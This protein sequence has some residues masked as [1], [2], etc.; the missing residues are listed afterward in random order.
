M[1][2]KILIFITTILIVGIVLS[3]VFLPKTEITEKED[4]FYRFKSSQEIYSLFTD[5]LNQFRHSGEM[6][7]TDMVM[8]RATGEDKSDMQTPAYSETN[9]QV[10]GVDEAD[11]IKTDGEYIYLIRNN[12]DYEKYIQISELI[13]VKA[14]QDIVS[15]NEY[16]NFH[17]NEMFIEK[18]KVVLFGNTQV[19]HNLIY[20]EQEGEFAE[21]NSVE[22]DTDDGILEENEIVSPT[23][24]R[25]TELTSIKIIDIKDKENQN[26][27]KSYDFEGN[28]KTSRKINEHVYFV[29]DSYPK[30][31]DLDKTPTCNQ[32]SP[33]YRETTNDENK[34]LDILVSCEN[35]GYISPINPN[36]FITVI[37]IDLETL[38]LEKEV[39]VGSSQNIYSSKNNLYIAQTTWPRYDNIGEPIEEYFE[40]TV[41]TKFNLDKGKIKYQ[42]TGRVKGYVLNQ[43][44]MDEDKE[45]FRIATT[46]SANWTRNIGSGRLVAETITDTLV[47]PEENL[48][49]NNLYVLD[50][51]LKVIGKIEDIAPGEKIYSARFM[52]DK[53]YMI[54]FVQ[55]DPLFVIDLKDPE[56]PKILGELKIPGYSD[57]LHPYSENYL[58]GIGKEVL[59]NQDPNNDFVYEQGVKISL[60]D[61]TDLENPKEVYKEV[62]GDRGTYSRALNDHKAFFFDKEKDLLIIPITLA[63]H[64]RPPENEWMYGTYTYQGMYVYKITPE[65]GFNL[66]GKITHSEDGP[67]NYNNFQENQ[68]VKRTLYVGDVLYTFSENR[69]QLNNLN[70]LE[71]IKKIYFK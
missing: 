10:K 46:T 58:I 23:Y 15:R 18:D 33:L 19:D 44:S 7:Q 43:F 17:I 35:I 48:S 29:I 26:I 36:G 59:E 22:A 57:Y 54:T 21:I 68:I 67:N 39:I 2:R 61:V 70:N 60:F 52:Q 20:P 62:I 25:K 34:E 8:E 47:E 11:I 27:L 64:K 45:N 30:F 63:Q 5:N 1:N 55:I 32:I 13:I 4:G 6:L 24:V 71:L 51:D 3:L 38:K 37:G 69:L 16:N 49:K 53:A 31:N 66:L 50:K 28:Y 12:Y 65:T 9:I 14:N 41:I 42:T 56:N 40:E